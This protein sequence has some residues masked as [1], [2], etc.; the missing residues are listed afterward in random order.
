MASL[1]GKVFGTPTDEITLVPSEDFI[2]AFFTIR[3]MYYARGPDQ[4]RKIS[5]FEQGRDI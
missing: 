4:A 1:Q 2:F 5:S 3:G